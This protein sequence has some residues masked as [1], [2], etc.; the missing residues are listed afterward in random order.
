MKPYQNLSGDSGIRAYEYGPDWIQIQFEHGGT[1]KYTSS[2]IGAAN[3]K[4][5][6]RLANSGDELNTFI[7]SHPAVKDGYSRRL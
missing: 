1:Y 4:T 3:L 7:N 6:K 5:L 2:G